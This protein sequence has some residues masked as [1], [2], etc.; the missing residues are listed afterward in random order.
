MTVQPY[1]IIAT[2]TGEYYG[3]SATIGEV[4]N[5]VLWD[6]DT[7]TWSPPAGTEARADPS[8]TLQIGPCLTGVL[9]IG[10]PIETVSPGTD[11]G[12]IGSVTR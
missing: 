6:G 8:G 1:A 5:I 10:D 4:V 11:A 7:A 2:A 3:A 9:T 12:T